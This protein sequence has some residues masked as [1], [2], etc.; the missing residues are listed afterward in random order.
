MAKKL[1]K[2]EV[3][4]LASLDIGTKNETVQNPFTGRSAE[5]TPELVALYDCIQGCQLLEDY[6]DFDRARYLFAKLDQEA[7][8]ILID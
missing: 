7:Y 6:T 1:T 8:M 4:L 3:K 2:A 5:L